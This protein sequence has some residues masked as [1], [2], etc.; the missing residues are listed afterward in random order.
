MAKDLIRRMTFTPFRDGKKYHLRIYDLHQRDQ[1][2]KSVLG[3]R[4]ADR[5]GVIFTGDDFHC[6][7]MHA[8]DSHETAMAL[9]GFLTLRPGDTDP[10]YFDS[11]TDRQMAFAQSLAC[12]FIASIVG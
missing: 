1:D 2:G 8:I 6:S 5:D 4:F 10:E 7:P 11:Y 3:Y 12:E 9:L